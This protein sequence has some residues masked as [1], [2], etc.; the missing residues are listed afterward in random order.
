MSIAFT[1]SHTCIYVQIHVW[2]YMLKWCSAFSFHM[3]GCVFAYIYIYILLYVYVCFWNES[4]SK[5]YCFDGWLFLFSFFFYFFRLCSLLVGFLCLASL[6]GLI[7]RFI[8]SLFYLFNFTFFIRTHTHNTLN[9]IHSLTWMQKLKK[10]I[11]TYT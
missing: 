1:H 4:D 7:I 2:C 10:N 3:Y 6:F 5:P 11:T 9:T 8:P